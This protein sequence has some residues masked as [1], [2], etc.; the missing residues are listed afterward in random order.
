MPGSLRL[1][2]FFNE[3]R[4]SEPKSD[5]KLLISKGSRAGLSNLREVNEHLPDDI[6]DSDPK[7]I[8]DISA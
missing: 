2:L 8:E 4:S 7:Q 3:H 5:I 1:R 6:V